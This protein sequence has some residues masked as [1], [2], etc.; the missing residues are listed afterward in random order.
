YMGDE[1]VIAWAFRIQNIVPVYDEGNNFAGTRGGYG[2]GQNPVAW[3]YR[4]KDDVNKN[5]LFFGNV[6]AEADVWSGLTFRTSFGLKY[7]NYDGIDIAYPTPEF[8]EARFNIGSRE[9]RADGTAWR[10]TSTIN[11][12]RTSRKPVLDLPPGTEA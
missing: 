7:E 4:A 3:A 5:N 9:Y 6:F 8:S 1:S 12:N 10:W 11:H 2:N